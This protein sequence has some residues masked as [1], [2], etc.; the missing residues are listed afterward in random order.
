MASIDVRGVTLEVDR[1]GSGP[2]LVWGHGLTGS[3]ASEDELGIIDWDHLR[4]GIDLVRYDARGHGASGYTADPLDYAWD[5][6]ALDQLALADEIGIERYVAGG[7]SMGAATALHAACLAPER[8]EALV[9]MIPPTAW[10]TRSAQVDVYETMASIIDAR[11]VEPLIAAGAD[12]APPDPFVGTSDWRDRSARSMRAADPIRLSG[13][14][15]GAATADLPPRDRVAAIAV[16][17]LVLAWTGDPGHPVS[18]A[19]ELGALLPAAE[20]HVAS[21]RAELEAWGSLIASFVAAVS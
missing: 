6:M 18:T 12:V 20:V 19:D 15:R 10:E 5:R 11:G 17:V 3:R 14:F 7:V 21:E 13:V 4:A 8:I 1:D 2:T 9:L 16:P